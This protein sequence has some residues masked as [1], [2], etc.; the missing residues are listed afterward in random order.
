MTIRPRSIAIRP[1]RS[2]F[3]NIR[4]TTSRALPS[5][6]A[7]ADA[8]LRRRRRGRGEGAREPLGDGAK[9]HVLHGHDEVGDP[10]GVGAQNVPPKV[11]IFRDQA[12][13]SSPCGTIRASTSVSAKP[14]AG[15]GSSSD[16]RRGSSR[17]QASPAPLCGR[18]VHLAPRWRGEADPHLAADD[19]DPASRKVAGGEDPVAGREADEPS[20]G[21]DRKPKRVDLA[22]ACSSPVGGSPWTGCPSSLSQT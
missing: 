6:A 4:L 14:S 15:S 22:Q 13:E 2:N 8:S 21:G 1:S 19:R 18:A 12:L 9:E 5:S 3:C 7:I 10:V 20:A 17:R 11:R 16:Q